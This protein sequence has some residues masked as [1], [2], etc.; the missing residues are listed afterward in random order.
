MSNNKK[1]ENFRKNVAGQE[2]AKATGQKKPEEQAGGRDRGQNKNYG[3]TQSRYNNQ[4][5]QASSRF[6]RKVKSEETVDDIR[7]DIE[8]IEKEIKLEIEEIRSLKL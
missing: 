4:D 5:R 3:R 2:E 7:V 1:R 8:R 6:V